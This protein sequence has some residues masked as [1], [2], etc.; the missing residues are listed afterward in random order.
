MWPRDNDSEL[1]AFYSRPDGS[2]QWEVKH[3]TY[4][5]PPWKAYL[6]E[7]DIE[8]KRGIRVHKKV[9][10]SL[11]RI[12]ASLWETFGKS[13]AAIEAVDLHQIGGAYY[14]RA[15]RGSKR[16]SNHARGIAIDIDP[17]DNPMSRSGRGDMDPRIVAAFKAEGW[18]WGGDYAGTKDKMHFEAIGNG[19]TATLTAKPAPP[20]SSFTTSY[21]PPVTPVSAP[22]IRH[23]LVAREAWVKGALPFVKKWESFV[24]TRYEDSGQWSIGYG[25]NA[26]KMLPDTVIS[27]AHASIMLAVYLRS[28]ADQVAE[29][30]QVSLTAN[31]GAALL[32]F[33]YNLGIGALKKSTL[34]K[35]L[36]SAD[37]FGAAN[38][39]RRWNKD[40]INGELVE[41]KG[42]TNRRKAERELLDTP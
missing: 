3:L 2:A 18:R 1:D 8:L 7:T 41:V 13:Q 14:F 9:A 6:A 10:D 22:A 27:E 31:Q 20:H 25:S 34:L 38:Q 42:L 39:F 21:E 17:Q 23:S 12:F 15:R 4:I 40:R 33:C 24:P 37:V 26:D 30:V 36:N 29:V 16:L 19:A 28:L 5:H 32:S 35:L 11:N